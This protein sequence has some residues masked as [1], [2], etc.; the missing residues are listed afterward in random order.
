MSG[1]CRGNNKL[2]T[3]KER[4]GKMAELDTVYTKQYGTN[5]YVMAQQRGSRL[6]NYVTIIEMTG[7]KRTI[8]RVH[9]T[10]AV[11]SDGLYM[12][13]PLVHTEFSRRTIHAQEYIWADLIDWKQKL[14]LFIDPTSPIVQQG[15]S[16]M[17]RTIDDIILD[18]GLDGYAFEGK[19]GLTPVA[20]PSTQQIAVTVGSSGGATNVGLNIEKLRQ[21]RSLFGKADIDLDDPANTLYMAISQTQL[22]DL[23]RTTEVT[24]GDYNIVKALVDG[25]VKKFMGFEFIQLERLRKTSG[26]R[27]CC[28][29]CKSG[30]QLALPQD[31]SME[32]N[33]RPDK[34]NAWQ[35][36]GKIKGGAGR[37][38]D[39]KVVQIFC[40]E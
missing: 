10:A 2:P 31:I 7:E 30:V 24:S 22:D 15:G 27:K 21:A 39:E 16:A 29:W 20:F 18:T 6:R 25:S 32:V 35:A 19:D 34:S 3:Q 11:R 37:P 13:T 9:P 5:V 36:L 28:A 4:I 33:T 26:I 40:A 8:E 23:L 1:M 14:N 17:G 12:D 38:E